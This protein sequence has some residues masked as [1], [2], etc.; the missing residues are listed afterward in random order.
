MLGKLREPVTG[1]LHQAAL[2]KRKADLAPDQEQRTSLLILEKGWN[3]LAQSIGF[4][5]RHE[6][7]LIEKPR[8]GTA[9]EWQPISSAPH[10]LMSA[11]LAVVDDDLS[12]VLGTRCRRDDNG[13]I[14][15]ATKQRI[16]IEPTHWRPWKH[17][18]GFSGNLLISV[19]DDDAAA[20]TSLRSLLRSLDCRAVDFASADEFLTSHLLSETAC[21]ISDLQMPKTSGLELQARLK[22]QGCGLPIIFISGV[23]D[24]K[25][26]ASA[27]ANGASD[28]LRKP[29]TG[30]KLI[31]S[32]ERAVT[33]VGTI[34]PA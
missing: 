33:G 16:D 25:S 17:I 18:L 6:Y 5:E 19:V 2:A 30:E 12:I 29:V 15:V 7:F 32:L 20:R 24:E 9:E 3:L 34:C 13:W 4:K 22:A 21:L 10:G 14:A 31:A 28:F 23:A 26:R 8:C 11:E 1:C 27:L